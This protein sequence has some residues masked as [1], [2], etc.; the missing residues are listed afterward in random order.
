MVY[1]LST[2][3]S[4]RGHNVSVYTTADKQA[5]VPLNQEIT[6]EGVDITYFENALGFLSDRNIKIPKR[7]FSK[8]LKGV[9]EYDAIH[10]HEHRTILAALV[11]KVAQRNNIPYI[12]Q[13]HGSMGYDRGRSLLKE[14]FDSAVGR[15]MIEEADKLLAMSEGEKDE[16]I[17]F[18]YPE[19]KIEVVPNGI[20]GEV[21]KEELPDGLE[22]QL[23]GKDIVLYLGRLSEIKGLPLLIR[24]F[25]QVDISSARLVIVG[26]DNG[27]L[28]ELKQISEEEEVT[29]RISFTGPIYGDAKY[30][31]YSMA[32]M[33]VLP[34]KYEAFP[35]TV[36]EAGLSGTPVA[37]SE[38]CSIS[39]DLREENA[40]IIFE[41]KPNV[42]ARD[43]ERLL[44]DNRLR[45]ELGTRLNELV[46][47]KYIWK[48]LIPQIEDVYETAAN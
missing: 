29:D 18:G 32:E 12:V 4:D 9:K 41:R 33:Y 7:G 10:V 43:I 8:I 15:K 40:G 34:S 44:R 45:Q 37:I 13:S 30:E 23:E 35:T 19:S 2:R 48:S 21:N 16:Y 17:G 25:S 42:L 20:S 31:L 26:P 22:R 27:V 36:L 46:E 11:T 5:D 24:A 1:E 38:K 14:I 39:K 47:E 6:D 3:L 28:S